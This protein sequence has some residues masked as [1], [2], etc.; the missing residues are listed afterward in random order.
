[1]L[2]SERFTG[3]GALRFL[4]IIGLMSD[5]MLSSERFDDGLGAL[6]TLS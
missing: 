2:S 3:L 6:L 4:G 5:S 1:M